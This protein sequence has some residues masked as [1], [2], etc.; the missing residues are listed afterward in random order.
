MI[1]LRG[2]SRV[3]LFLTLGLAIVSPALPQGSDAKD[4]QAV[5]DQKDQKKKAD[6]LEAFIKKYPTSNRRP[7]AD[8]DLVDIWAKSN[9]NGKILSFAE[10]YKKAPP[11]PDAAVKSKIYTQAMAA[12]ISSNN[13]AKASEFGEAAI[14]ADPNNFQPLY[15]MAR[16]GMP[17]PD[18]AL[19]YAQKAL[20][21]PKPEGIPQDAYNKQM[22]A[23]HGAVALPL[24]IQKKYADARDHL[25]AVLKADPKNQEAQY[26]HG[27]ASVNLM[28]EAV[29]TA[30]DA[31]T[32]MMKAA[33][34]QNQAETDAAKAKQETAQKTA[35][36]LR[37]VALD[38]LAKAVAIGGPYT[39]QAKPL[40]DSLYQNKNKSMDG[41][42]QLIVDKKKEL[43]L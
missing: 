4:W 43:G 13:A 26:R 39:E 42:D 34:A 9:E 32:A 28:G 29:R 20:S 10:E 30:Q 19:E 25:E 27:F 24:F 23:L 8:K 1:T 33:A 35:L 12:A 6:L 2:L 14:E 41:A 22:A 38:S 36:E 17:N 40:F 21:L 5:Q 16:T 15:V 37:D 31:N 3:A 18:K 11:S 7:G